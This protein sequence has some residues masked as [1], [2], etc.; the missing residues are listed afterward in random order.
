MSVRFRLNSLV[1]LTITIIVS[2]YLYVLKITSDIDNELAEIEKIDRFEENVTR[3]NLLMEYF[4]ATR[5]IKYTNSLLTLINELDKAKDDIAGFD[6]F[7]LLRQSIPSVK[8]ALNLLLKI[9]NNP[10]FYSSEEDRIQLQERALVLIRSDL[11]QLMSLAFKTSRFR[12]ANIRNLQ[13]EQR[14]YI[15]AT[16]IPFI[17]LFVAIIYRTQSQ[18]LN[19]LSKLRV[20]AKNLAM[21]NLDERIEI[22]SKDEFAEL[23]TQFNTMAEKLESTIENERVINQ[24]LESKTE[25]LKMSNQELEQFTIMVSNDLQE[26]LRMVNSFMKLL[27]NKY[28]NV[29]DEK[30]LMYIRYA[31]DGAK[32]MKQTIL[33]LLEYSKIGNYEGEKTLIDLN[34]LV[35]EVCALQARNLKKKDGT[36]T[37]DKLP[38]IVAH[39]LPL[40]QI[41]QHLL[42]NSIHYSKVNEPLYVHVGYEEMHDFHKF[43]FTDN[44]I[45]IDPIYHEKIFVIFQTL[46]SESS[47]KGTGIGLAIIKKIVNY[48]EGDISVES[49]AGEGTS[50]VFTLKK[51]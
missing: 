33:D 40:F 43:S 20:G 21:G 41:F 18:I 46:D 5:D 36:V 42:S 13:V 31:S 34:H 24:H 44:G 25:E 4:I 7:N 26:P 22:E 12:Q 11:R 9:E 47:N 17:L 45:G 1:I 16:M 6:R 37:L 14:G 3:L 2:L 38:R 27:E 50:F 23:A 32:R 28:S 49:K 19:S 15:L 51:N 10:D 30:G 48:L 35:D 39:H 8:K 29:L